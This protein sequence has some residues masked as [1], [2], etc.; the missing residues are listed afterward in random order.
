MNRLPNRIW[1]AALLTASLWTAAPA[2]VRADTAWP[3]SP[4]KL[5][6][7]FAAGG[8]TDLLARLV[9]EGLGKTLNQTVIVQNKP[10]AGGNIGAAEVARATPD[11]YTLLMGTPGP[12]AIN[13][14]VYPKMAF[15]PARDFAAVSYVAD[16]P[17][18]I[19]TSPA[20]GMKNIDDVLA[21]ARQQPGSLNWGSPGV[22]STGH[23]ALE[24]LK[25]LGKV[26]LAHVPYK[27]ASQASA[28]LLAGHIDLAGDNVPSA[29]EQIRAGN[30]VALGVASDKPLD[31]L[32][33]VA[34]VSA[35]VPGYLLPSWFVIVAPAGTPA[36]VIDKISAAIDAFE[37]QAATRE[38]FR[39]LGA[40]PIGGNAARLTDHLKSEQARYGELLKDIKAT[41]Q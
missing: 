29:L 41:P 3:A 34:P 32:P 39:A 27:G 19:L 14:Y 24:L 20:S 15:D 10:G 35:T 28:D 18:V 26:E 7:P 12:L 21:R 16:V 36:P 22:G 40:V 6:V 17:N 25:K 33:G 5:V 37:K 1:G 23:I 30:L 4:I 38:K 11:G 8:T 31:V 9:A 2:T 13:P